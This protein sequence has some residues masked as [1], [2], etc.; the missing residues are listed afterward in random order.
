M[1]GA[2]LAPRCRMLAA[3]VAVSVALCLAWAGTARIMSVPAIPGG[4][5][6]R[7]MALVRFAGDGED[8]RRAPGRDPGR[9]RGLDLV[10]RGIDGLRAQ[11]AQMARAPFAGPGVSPGSAPAGRVQSAGGATLIRAPGAHRASTAADAACLLTHRGSLVRHPHSSSWRASA[12]AR[13]AI[14]TL[15]VRTP[16]P[17][18]HAR[19]KRTKPMAEVNTDGTQRPGAASADPG[20]D[21]I[22]VLSA[23]G[24]GHQDDLAGALPPGV[25]SGIPPPGCAVDGAER[26]GLVAGPPARGCKACGDIGGSGGPLGAVTVPACPDARPGTG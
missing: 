19:L 24:P 2:S 15:A 4:H 23:P 9:V 8:C 18:G 11:L 10:R 17:G 26:P 5:A 1:V 25:F 12:P 21:G 14:R 20:Q 13:F 7:A 16:V 22:R 3:G 6:V